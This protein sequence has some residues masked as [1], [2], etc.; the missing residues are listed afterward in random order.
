MPVSIRCVDGR[1]T[2][3]LYP[4]NEPVEAFVMPG[5]HYL[6]VDYIGRGPGGIVGAGGAIW[7]DAEA[8]HTYQ[9][10]WSIANRGVRFW[11]ADESTGAI[12]G[13]I[14]GGEPDPAP[15]EQVCKAESPV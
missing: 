3:R 4:P 6:G 10:R 2:I 14:L 11:L 9:V 13:G 15:D 12:V 7:L 8:G 1:R 5:R